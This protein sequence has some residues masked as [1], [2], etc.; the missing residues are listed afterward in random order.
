ML[1]YPL[2]LASQ[3]FC[4][5]LNKLFCSLFSLNNLQPGRL[6]NNDQSLPPHP[7]PPSSHP[8]T[9]SNTLTQL[10]LSPSA[11][12]FTSSPSH[13]LTTTSSSHL[14]PN[15]SHHFL[16]HSPPVPYLMWQYSTTTALFLS[17]QHISSI[18]TLP[19]FSLHL[20]VFSLTPTLSNTPPAHHHHYYYSTTPSIHLHLLSPSPPSS[21]YTLPINPIFSFQACARTLHLITH[22][23]Q[24]CL[25]PI[26]SPILSLLAFLSSSLFYSS[27]TS[28][29]SSRP[30][31]SKA[32]P[33]TSHPLNIPYSWLLMLMVV[34]L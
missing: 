2:F 20:S 27:Q 9:H 28:P 33:E 4:V 34:A 8:P 5:E 11:L 18:N 12:F 24:H 6:H 25:L 17:T 26:T 1:W 31:S 16:P 21:S 14:V 13:H 3:Q 15:H 32:H 23:F 10:A 30:L 7:S 22:L 29:P 19:S